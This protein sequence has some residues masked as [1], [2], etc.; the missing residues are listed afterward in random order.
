MPP[1]RL[2][3]N[4]QSTFWSKRTV[5]ALLEIAPCTT[6]FDLFSL[7]SCRSH[8]S[9]E[10]LVSLPQDPGKPIKIDPAKQSYPSADPTTDL[11]LWMV[12]SEWNGPSRGYPMRTT[13]GEWMV[14]VI[15]DLPYAMLASLEAEAQS[16]TIGNIIRA[17]LVTAGHGTADDIIGI[18]SD[19]YTT[20]EEQIELITAAKS[21]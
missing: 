11:R 20:E 5:L 1:V 10:T 19:R 16:H 14:P 17:A 18:K 6:V 2:A 12:G 21:R 8:H 15:V 4:G 7:I 3:P 13:S 9:K